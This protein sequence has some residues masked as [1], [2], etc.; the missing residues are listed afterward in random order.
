MWICESHGASA[1][2]VFHQL[3]YEIHLKIMLWELK[4]GFV[5]LNC[6]TTLCGCAMCV[7]FHCKFWPQNDFD[8]QCVNVNWQAW[9][10]P[11][12]GTW[13]FVWCASKWSQ[14][15]LMIYNQNSFIFWFWLMKQLSVWF[16]TGQCWQEQIFS[17]NS[18]FFRT[19]P[20]S[21]TSLRTSNEQA[22]PNEQAMVWGFLNSVRRSWK[23][24]VFHWWW[25]MQL[26]YWSLSPNMG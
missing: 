5:L 3:C 13:F 22:Q 12:R 21:G 2:F 9:I 19:K 25:F 24:W 1:Y 23:I 7:L 16:I 18:I 15:S 26:T 8:C 4:F 10:T 20:V 11:L 14:H 17:R 6:S